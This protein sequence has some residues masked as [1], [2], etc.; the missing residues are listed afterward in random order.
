MYKY[1]CRRSHPEAPPTALREHIAFHYRR[2]IGGSSR[3]HGS[4]PQPGYRS[5]Y[6]MNHW[7]PTKGEVAAFAILQRSSHGGSH[8][9]RVGLRPDCGSCSYNY[10]TRSRPQSSKRIRIRAENP[11]ADA[12][13]ATNAAA[14]QTCADTFNI[15]QSPCQSRHF[16]PALFVFHGTSVAVI[17][18]EQLRLAT[19]RGSVGLTR[20]FFVAVLF[21]EITIA[22]DQENL[23]G[24]T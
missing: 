5:C 11:H 2:P 17:T 14:G 21:Q 16:R 9:R 8:K 22:R 3:S 24:Y 15:A 10:S 13:P 4:A 19:L 1:R 23:I 18:T 7:R 12:S 20:T 6:I